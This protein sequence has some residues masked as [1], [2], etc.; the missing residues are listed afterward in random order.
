MHHSSTSLVRPVLA[1]A[2]L[3]LSGWATQA[4]AVELPLA[5]SYTPAN[6]SALY[7]TALGISVSADGKRLLAKTTPFGA[8]AGGR[9]TFG[10]YPWYVTVA[11]FG[12][13]PARAANGDR[14][15]G[16]GA[17]TQPA[18]KLYTVARL[19]PG[20][21]STYQLT[22]VDMSGITR[23]YVGGWTGTMTGT[24]TTDGKR[25]K[26]TAANVV[27]FDIHIDGTE[28]RN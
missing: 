3:A 9:L 2:T 5:L 13:S 17:L 12:Y 22:P 6:T 11:D 24:L 7:N 21:L 19:V 16:T 18:G 8:Y 10:G 26:L 14:W 4:A 28:T 25:G 1:A 27:D 15:R 20:T 23:G